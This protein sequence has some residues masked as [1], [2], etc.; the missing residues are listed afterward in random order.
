MCID[1][2]NA[3]VQ[4]ISR[5]LRQVCEG[6]RALVAQHTVVERLLTNMVSIS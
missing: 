1:K 4:L 5:Q 6:I 3:V 2:P